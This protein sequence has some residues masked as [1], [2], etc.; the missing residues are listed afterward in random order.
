MDIIDV[1]GFWLVRLEHRKKITA[2]I[3]R[4]NSPHNATLCVYTK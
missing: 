1:I 3:A 4:L 2:V